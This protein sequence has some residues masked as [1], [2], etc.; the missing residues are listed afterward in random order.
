MDWWTLCMMCKDC[1]FSDIFISSDLKR[2]RLRW[3]LNN[4][5]Q[6]MWKEPAMAWFKLLSRIVVEIK[7]FH[8]F[9]TTYFTKTLAKN[10]RLSGFSYT[11]LFEMFV[12]VLTTCHTKYT[13]NRSICIFYLIEQHSKFLLY[14]LQVLYI[15]T[16]CDSTNINTIIEFVPNCL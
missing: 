10:V 3:L 11:G 15:C 9:R 12:G 5:V 16:L 1:L 13:W 14:T 6:V 7:Q 4:E 8:Y 2:R